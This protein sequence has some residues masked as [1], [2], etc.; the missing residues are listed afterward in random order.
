MIQGK[1]N[2]QSQII[3]YFSPN[4]SMGS[5]VPRDYIGKGWDCLNLF[6]LGA[7]QQGWPHFISTKKNR[8]AYLDYFD[9]VQWD[10][11]FSISLGSAVCILVSLLL[12]QLNS[13]SSGPYSYLFVITNSP[14]SLHLLQD[15]FLH[16][17]LS[18]HNLL[19]PLPEFCSNL[20]THNKPKHNFFK[21]GF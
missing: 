1:R 11:F 12:S 3:Q 5:C 6:L 17:A 13:C 21:N 8:I 14:S 19:P 20:W 2:Y 16:I 7:L 10:W 18:L 4:C 15:S 9:T